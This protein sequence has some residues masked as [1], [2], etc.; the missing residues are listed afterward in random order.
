MRLSKKK[1]ILISIFV[2]LS[3]FAAFQVF[4]IYNSA[5]QML[6]ETRARQDGKNRVAVE[7]KILTPHLN[8]QNRNF[9]EHLGCSRIYN[10]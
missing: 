4:S 6:A 7:T 5:R 10:I 9:A 8:N 1:I 3:S 2:S